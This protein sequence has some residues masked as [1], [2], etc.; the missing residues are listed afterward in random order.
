M[1][2]LHSEVD[3]VK[4]VSDSHITVFTE[5]IWMTSFEDWRIQH[6]YL[7][8]SFQPENTIFTLLLL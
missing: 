3:G 8:N 6:K 1:L 7:Q 5:F 4:V 2:Q